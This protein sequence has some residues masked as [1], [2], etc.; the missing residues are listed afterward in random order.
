MT[1]VIKPLVSPLRRVGQLYLDYQHSYGLVTTTMDLQAVL[2]SKGAWAKGG[3]LPIRTYQS[4][5]C[6][7]ILLRL[8]CFRGTVVGGCTDFGLRQGCIQASF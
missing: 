4:L 3:L 7:L 2:H 1:V 6:G 5:L 8:R